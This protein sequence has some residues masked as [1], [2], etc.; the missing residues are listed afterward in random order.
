MIDT[1]TEQLPLFHPKLGEFEAKVGIGRASFPMGR[2]RQLEQAKQ[3]AILL[4]KGSFDRCITADDVVRWYAI[5]GIN[6]PGKLGNAMGSLFR[7]SCWEFTGRYV[8][9]KRVS[10]HANTIRVWKLREA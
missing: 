10:R 2:R 5:R 6:L 8:K 4:A 3:T 1:N 7:A 9:S